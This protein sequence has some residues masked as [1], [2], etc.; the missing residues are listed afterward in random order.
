MLNISA[1]ATTQCLKIILELSNLHFLFSQLIFQA[2]ILQTQ[3][4]NHGGQVCHGRS[5]SDRLLLLL[6]RLAACVPLR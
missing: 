6:F 1:L 4:L 5:I 3:L 2:P